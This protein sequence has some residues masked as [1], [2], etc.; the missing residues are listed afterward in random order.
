M[1][2]DCPGNWGFSHQFPGWLLGPFAQEWPPANLHW[3]FIKRTRPSFSSSWPHWP[4]SAASRP[5]RVPHLS[6]AILSFGLSTAW[7]E[8]LLP[9]WDGRT[10]GRTPARERAW[11][12]FCCRCRRGGQLRA[13]HFP[14]ER[15]HHLKES[16]ASKTCAKASGLRFLRVDETAKSRVQDPDDQTDHRYSHVN[17][18]GR[19]RRWSAQ[20]RVVLQSARD[21]ML[22]A[23]VCLGLWSDAHLVLVSSGE[24]LKSGEAVD[25]HHFDLVGC[26]VHLGHNDVSAVFVFLAELL[27]DGSQLFAVAA[28]RRIWNVKQRQLLS[29]DE[30]KAHSDISN[31][32]TTDKRL[33]TC[34]FTWHC[35][36]T[37]SNNP[38]LV[39]VEKV[40]HTKNFH[41]CQSTSMAFKRRLTEFH[42][43]VLWGIKGNFL[44]VLANQNLNWGFVPVFRD[45]LAH[46]VGLQG[47]TK[48][49]QTQPSFAGCQHIGHV[50]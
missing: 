41:I 17:R 12:K 14:R 24:E 30:E 23:P 6:E 47:K 35:E 42:K 31:C 39:N 27:P 20:S 37:S 50:V 13:E 21:S 38:P 18:S 28:P 34:H 15:G 36:E 4:G 11:P 5:S 48:L 29:L 7:T 32:I 3:L 9:I 25:F 2:S 43:D 46:E 33:Q 49:L 8:S 19:A 1:C 40:W 26:G 45:V 44:E 16:S 10:D 22:N